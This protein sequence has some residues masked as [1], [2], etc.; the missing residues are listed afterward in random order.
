MLSLWLVRAQRCESLLE[1]PWLTE[2][3]VDILCYRLELLR[4]HAFALG[5]ELALLE[6]YVFLKEPIVLY[7]LLL[8]SFS[9]CLI[10][11]SD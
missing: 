10:L 11:L 5:L 7:Y 6:L 1:L 8:E 2:R 3:S 9:Q 4:V